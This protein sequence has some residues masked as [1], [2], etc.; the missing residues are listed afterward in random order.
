MGIMDPEAVDRLLHAINNE[1]PRPFIEW[2][3]GWPHEIEA[4]LIDAVLSIRARYGQSHNGVRGSI[5]RY[6]KEHQDPL[7]SLGRLATYEEEDLQAVLGVK[8]RTSGRSKAGAIIEAAQALKDLGVE[9]AS[10]VDPVLHKGA[11][12]SVHG[13]GWVTWEYF[14]MLLGKP[15]VKADTWI[16]RWVSHAL[17]RTDDHVSSHEARELLHEAHNQMEAT[18]KFETPSL[19]QLDHAIWSHARRGNLPES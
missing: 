6:R 8:Q 16:V 1:L 2:P 11:Y 13:L 17:G 10:Q 5:G 7:D 18:G 19:T 3:G 4:A 14:T 15:G 9:Q 12:V